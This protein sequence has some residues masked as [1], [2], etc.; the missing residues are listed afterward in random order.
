MSRKLLTIRIW[1]VLLLIAISLSGTL[2]FAQSATAVRID[3][4][5]LSAQV[6]D[7]GNISIK[8]DNIANLTAFELH[9]SFNPSVLEV[10]QITNGGFVLADITPQ[11]TFN[12]TA[13]TIDY[14]VAQMNRPAAQ[15]SGT[16]LN[17]SFRAK[18]SGISAL[19]LR[20]TP[21]VPGG[22]LLSDL[23]GISIQASWTGGSVNVGGVPSPTFTPNGPTNTPITPTNTPTVPTN[24]PTGPTN[25]PTATPMP[26][27]PGGN[28]GTH[29]VRSGEWLYCIGRA[30]GVSPLAIAEKNGIW[31]PYLIFSNQKLLIPNIG[32]TNM[33]TGPVCQSQFSVSTTPSSPTAVPTTAI[34]TTPNPTNPTAIPPT[35]TAVPPSACRATYTVVSGDSL[36]QIAIS[37]GSTYTELARVNQISNPR[38]IYSGQ[39]LCIP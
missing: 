17:I 33:S 23:N 5:A 35:A 22:L 4:S 20:G 3:P 10:L 36:Y 25:T 30:Y 15:G 7:N 29:V 37:Y 28:L 1:L 8:V 21:A 6:N 27:A 18:A 32:W 14:A 16:I 19:A 11:N 39:R 12:N 9:L 24:T 26:I 38:L 2:V 31:W 13:G 34:P